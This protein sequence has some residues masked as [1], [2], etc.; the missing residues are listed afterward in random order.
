MKT[1]QTMC[2]VCGKVFESKI[3]ETNGNDF[4]SGECYSDVLKN[5]KYFSK[6]E[7]NRRL[8]LYKNNKNI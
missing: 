4:C 8:E 3:S 7:V 2:C 1:Y 6:N 5:N